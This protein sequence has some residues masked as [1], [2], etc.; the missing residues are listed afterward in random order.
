MEHEDDNLELSADELA[1]ELAMHRQ[2]IAIA[3]AHSPAAMSEARSIN[4]Q[5]SQDALEANEN[6]YSDA[7]IE[8][9]IAVVEDVI[10][11]AEASAK[12]SQS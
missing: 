8:H 1:A 7:Y 3:I 5:F 11:H 6:A 12:R 10:R 9:A 2:L 4:L